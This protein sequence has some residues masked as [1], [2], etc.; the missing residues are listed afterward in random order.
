MPPRPPR[1][2]V[3]G[4]A[5]ALFDCHVVDQERIESSLPQ[6]LLRTVGEMYV[7]LVPA[8]ALVILL[9]TATGE[10]G[11]IV[12]IL[13]APIA[14]CYAPLAMRSGR[15]TLALWRKRRARANVGRELLTLG[16]DYRIL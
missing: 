5:V 1:A 4:T 7:M 10:R 16:R 2:Y 6:Q 12:A 3:R 13:L 8:V 15:A 9:T 11:L 14:F